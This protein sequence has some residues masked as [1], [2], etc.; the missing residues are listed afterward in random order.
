[1]KMEILLLLM[2][3]MYSLHKCSPPKMVPIPSH[4]FLTAIITPFP[5]A[6]EES[7]LE[8]KKWKLGFLISIVL[9]SVFLTWEI[10]I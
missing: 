1:M 2:L 5:C 9:E 4:A 7:K 8:E 6:K 10:G 3:F